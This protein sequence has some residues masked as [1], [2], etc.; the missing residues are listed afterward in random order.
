MGHVESFVWEL[1]DIDVVTHVGIGNRAL[2]SCMALT[3]LLQGCLQK[4]N[5]RWHH[6]STSSELLLSAAEWRI[7]DQFRAYDGDVVDGHAEDLRYC[8]HCDGIA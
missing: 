3:A 8:H 1:E 5:S 2:M 6:R 7:A 4:T